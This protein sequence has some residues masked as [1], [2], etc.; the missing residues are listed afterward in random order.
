MAT[1]DYMHMQNLGDWLVKLY[2]PDLRGWQMRGLAKEAIALLDISFE[3]GKN[4]VFLIDFETNEEKF[5]KLLALDYRRLGSED[6][7]ER[8]SLNLPLNIQAWRDSE[9]RGVGPL[10]FQTYYS[11]FQTLSILKNL[12]SLNKPWQICFDKQPFSHWMQQICESNYGNVIEVYKL[13]GDKGFIK[14]RSISPKCLGQYSIINPDGPD[15]HGDLKEIGFI[16]PW[17]IIISRMFIGFL[18]LGG[19]DYFGF[20]K[21]CGKFYLVQR[22]GR[23]QFCSNNCRAYVSLIKHGKIKP[24]QEK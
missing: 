16:F 8:F 6:Q 4:D 3:I 10:Y 9:G 17:H 1:S 13:T 22:M 5:S 14:T 20:C 11:R 24:K 19:Q 18:E 12:I 23:R 2:A 21:H 7:R 15:E